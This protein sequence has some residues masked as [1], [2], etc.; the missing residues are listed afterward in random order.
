MRWLRWSAR[1][2]RQAK[3]VIVISQMRINMGRLIISAAHAR[4][5]V[6]RHA[7]ACVYVCVL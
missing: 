6:M 2:G 7:C 3:H 4:L 5:R 1:N